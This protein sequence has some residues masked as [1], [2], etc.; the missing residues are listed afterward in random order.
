MSDQKPET[1]PVAQG[2]RCVRPP[3]KDT[4]HLLFSQVGPFPPC[5]GCIC[6]HRDVRDHWSQWCS[7]NRCF[8]DPQYLRWSHTE[9]GMV[10]K[11]CLCV[12]AS[13]R[14]P[15][16][17]LGRHC[18]CSSP[19]STARW[20]TAVNPSACIMV[21]AI[22]VAPNCSTLCHMAGRGGKTKAA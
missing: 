19:I 18:M 20:A 12:L 4:H 17:H 13:K 2:S 7:C 5:Q 16:N 14:G 1:L 8:G 9:R 11:H 3:S 10:T 22:T 6:E 15:A 21:N